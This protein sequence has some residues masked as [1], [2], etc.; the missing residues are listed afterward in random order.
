MRHILVLALMAA[1]A[2]QVGCIVFFHKE[3]VPGL[4]SDAESLAFVDRLRG[5]TLILHGGDS[6]TL[7]ALGIAEM[8]EFQRDRLARSLK[9]MAPYPDPPPQ[10]GAKK[11]YRGLLIRNFARSRRVLASLPYVQLRHMCGFRPISLFPIRIKVPPD[12][13][14]VVEYVL[15][16][17]MAKLDPK[18]VAEADLLDR[19]RKVEESARALK[20]GVWAPLGEQLLE[21][22]E[23]G[24][25]AEARRL[26][27]AGAPVDYVGKPFPGPDPT[28]PW[29]HDRLLNSQWWARSYR[30]EGRTPLM[31]AVTWRRRDIAEILRRCGAE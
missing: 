28:T 23:A 31:I 26:L 24:D 21:A 27:D 30:H 29:P 1:A 3:H 2:C 9:E 18:G 5:R 8:S 19:Y 13:V 14:D 11:P 7:D 10:A 25:A 16:T 15:R 17:G 22:V 6:I 4:D 12:H 20:L